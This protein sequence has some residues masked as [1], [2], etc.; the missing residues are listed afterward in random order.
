M[1]FSVHVLAGAA[2]ASYASTFYTALPV[3]LVTHALL[4]MVP[5]HDY[6][7]I[8]PGVIDGLVGLLALA[9]FA[10]GPRP[11]AAW[12]AAGGGI[13]DLEVFLGYFNLVKRQWFPTHNGLLPHPQRSF[14]PGLWLQLLVAG[15]SA[16]RLVGL[17]LPQS[18]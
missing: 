11:V 1:Y 15:L 7:S 4:D 9:L 16:A 14:W 10:M 13:P 3:G 5:H 8:P 17:F 2:A 18:L 12:G 6:G